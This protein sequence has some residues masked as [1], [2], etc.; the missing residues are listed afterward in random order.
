MRAAWLCICD[1][2]H[3][4]A[5]GVMV[6]VVQPLEQNVLSHP[7][8]CGAVTDHTAAFTT[9]QATLFSHSST[10]PQPPSL[11]L[12]HGDVGLRTNNSPS[13]PFNY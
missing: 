3:T 4:D 10:R 9:L 1:R 13:S 2:C 7:V 12:G 6:V 11:T 8:S 5:I